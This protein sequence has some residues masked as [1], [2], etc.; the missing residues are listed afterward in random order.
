[1]AFAAQAASHVLITGASGVGK[2]LAA[3]AVHALSARADGP[4]VSRNAATLPD[5]LADAEFFGNAANYPNPGMPERPGLVGEA[6]G[7]TL[8]LDEIGELSEPLQA[9]LLRVADAG[10]YQR[11]GE[12][13][14]RHADFVL[15]GAT[16]RD[17]SSLKHDLAARFP[18][19]LHVPG[20]AE[21]REDIPLIAEA[22]LQRAVAKMPPWR[23]SS[24]ITAAVR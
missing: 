3:R 1:M 11:L 9:K 19:R 14:P 4:W 22:L 17:P 12:A 10:E 15:V 8:F 20:L 23:A 16:N 18:V 24:A 5:G 6:A 7:G 21:R 13:T 2:E